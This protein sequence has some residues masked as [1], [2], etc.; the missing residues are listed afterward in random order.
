MD[1]LINLALGI[2]GSLIAAEIVFHHKRWC[3]RLVRAAAARIKDPAQ[4]EIK[5]EEWLA[6]LDEHVGVIASFSHSI[7]CWVGAPAVAAALKLPV[8]NKAANNPSKSATRFRFA[9]ATIEGRSGVSA[10]VLEQMIK[11]LSETTRDAGAQLHRLEAEMKEVMRRSKALSVSVSLLGLVGLL[12]S[13][14]RWF[15]KG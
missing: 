1:Y 3:R 9:R 2:A 13:V 11:Q 10:R 7:G 8:L 4:S 6:A 5:L 15:F 12:V 14:M